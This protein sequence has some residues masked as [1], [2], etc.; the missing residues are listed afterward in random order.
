M[1]LT[2]RR[3]GRLTV[4]RKVTLTL[5][6]PQTV[7]RHLYPAELQVTTSLHHFATTP[8]SRYPADTTALASLHGRLNG[9]VVH[10]STETTALFFL[11]RT[12]A[13]LSRSTRTF[14]ACARYCINRDN[15]TLHSVQ[16][17]G[18]PLKVNANIQCVCRFRVCARPD[19]RVN[20]KTSN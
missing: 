17:N 2:P 3:T 6:L 12:T 10:R 13:D 5:T 11:S 20:N 19:K 16:D 7:I 4:S 1:R 8:A 14:S 15:H 18:R 9:L